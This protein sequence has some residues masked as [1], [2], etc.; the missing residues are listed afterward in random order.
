MTS[1]TLDTWANWAI[2]LIMK[3]ISFLILSL[4]PKGGTICLLLK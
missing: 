4:Y 1:V 3:T 2:I